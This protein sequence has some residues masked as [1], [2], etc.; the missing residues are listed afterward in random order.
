MNVMILGMKERRRPC[1]RGSG[2]RSGNLGFGR[3]NGVFPG[4]SGMVFEGRVKPSDDVC[5]NGIG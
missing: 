5:D 3:N 4:K 2:R 1:R